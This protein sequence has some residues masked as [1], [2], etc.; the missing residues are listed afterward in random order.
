MDDLISRTALLESFV[1]E[2]SG[3]CYGCEYEEKEK[4][5][6]CKLIKYAP[7]IDAAPIVHGRWIDENPNDSLDPRMRCSICGVVECSFVRWRYCPNCGAKM[8]EKQ[9]ND[10]K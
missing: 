9:K 1:W 7:A 2:C 10:N 3:E 5:Y 4:P 6:Y 8:D